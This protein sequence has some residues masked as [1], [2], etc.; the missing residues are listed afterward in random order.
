MA[1]VIVG[2]WGVGYAVPFAK[3]HGKCFAFPEL[4]TGPR[5]DGHGCGDDPAFITAMAPYIAGAAFVRIKDFHASDYDGAMKDS[6]GAAAALKPVLSP[7]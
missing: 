7:H 4:A 1:S 3:A 6:H 2:T 5:P